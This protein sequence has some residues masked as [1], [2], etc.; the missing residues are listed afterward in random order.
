[1]SY[2]S[3]L[4]LYTFH[5]LFERARTRV[6]HSISCLPS[7]CSLCSSFVTTRYALQFLFAR[8]LPIVIPL[9]SQTFPNFPNSLPT[10]DSSCPYVVNRKLASGV[11]FQDNW[12]HPHFVLVARWY[13]SH[14]LIH[15]IL[16]IWV[17]FPTPPLNRSRITRIHLP[18]LAVP[19]SLWVLNSLVVQSRV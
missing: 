10:P 9:L 8:M 13:L 2:I 1:M 12:C 16:K 17:D 7:L 15:F 11:T 14:A 5:C 6:T 19:L 3:L 4:F 18:L